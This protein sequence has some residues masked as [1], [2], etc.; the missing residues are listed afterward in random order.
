[1]KQKSYDLVVVGGGPAGSTIS[2][3]VAKEGFSVLL[4]EKESFPRYHVGESL[5]P[6]TVHGICKVLGVEE[7]LK[8][9]KNKTG[10]F[11]LWGNSRDPWKFDFKQ[12]GAYHVE[13]AEFDNILLENA[14]ENQVEVIEEASVF[15][16]VD[17]PDYST[18]RYKN[19]QGER[20]EVTA[21][22]VADCSGG[23]SKIADVI[24]QKVESKFFQNVAIWG[25]FDGATHIGE[26]EGAILNEAIDEGWWWF[27]PL[28]GGRMSIGLVVDSKSLDGRKP[29]EV[30]YDTLKESEFFNKH[31]KH[32]TPS[33]DAPYNKLRTCK[34]YSYCR[35]QFTKGNILLV[36][37]A[38]CF[39]D[40]VFSSGVH[41]ATLAGYLGGLSINSVLKGKLSK[42]EALAEYAERYFFE[43]KN[44]YEFL[45]SFYD[46]SQSKDSYF[47]KA[48]TVLNTKEKNNEAFLSLITGISSGLVLNHEEEN[49]RDFFKQYEGI[50]EIFRMA[51]ENRPEL[52]MARASEGHTAAL[53]NIEIR[54]KMEFNA[55][56]L[57]K[58]SQEEKHTQPFSKRQLVPAS[59]G[60]FWDMIS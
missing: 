6:L 39:I 9:F 50:G 38:A 13:R 56:I 59:D 45:I 48:R 24:A 42:A 18:V 58:L 41:L 10:G 25:Y 49:V 3:I 5:L 17:A 7:K 4:L 23:N 11:F 32:C 30:F 43:Y 27:I 31:Y 47:W 28:S 44:F 8:S 16:V 57:V 53:K 51:Q 40:P 2:T 19:K 37:D 21:K 1:M 14:R 29:K 33:A 46:S 54:D 34:D 52:I 22:F 60:L 55:Q 35:E 36:G 12:L 15:S 20:Q 26:H